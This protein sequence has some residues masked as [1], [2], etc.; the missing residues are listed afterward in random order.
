VNTTGVLSPFFDRLERGSTLRWRG[1]VLQ[2]IGNLIESEG[3]FCSVGES[4]E[5]TNS[6]GRRYSGEVIG[7]RGST[8]LSMAVENPQGIR[9]GDQ[10]VAWGTRPSIRVGRL[11]WRATRLERRISRRT[12]R[13]GRWSGTAAS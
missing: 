2:V 6:S 9:Y 12:D 13:V 7:F 11:Y 4:C 10:I 5:I 8:L 3:P 1:R